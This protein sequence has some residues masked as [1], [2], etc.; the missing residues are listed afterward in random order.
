MLD[1]NAVTLTNVDPEKVPTGVYGEFESTIRLD[2]DGVE[3][4]FWKFFDKEKVKLFREDY[5]D[6]RFD[7]G[8]AV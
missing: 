2:H 6:G 4:R 1:F 8:D 7:N 3:K 5:K